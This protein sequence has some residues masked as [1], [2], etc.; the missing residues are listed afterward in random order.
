MLIDIICSFSNTAH[1]APQPQAQVTYAGGRLTEDAG[2]QL[3]AMLDTAGT[4]ITTMLD[5]L[6]QRAGYQPIRANVQPHRGV[7]GRI[8]L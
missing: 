7:L 4:R 1:I 5:A 3:A 2:A 6:M 8:F